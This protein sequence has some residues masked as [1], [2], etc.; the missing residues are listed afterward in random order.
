M[1]SS[2][3]I[4]E[5]ICVYICIWAVFVTIAMIHA[6]WPSKESPPPRQR[7]SST[8]RQAAEASV[9]RLQTRVDAGAS[10]ALALESVDV[11]NGKREHCQQLD[12]FR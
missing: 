12:I 2:L 4:Q 9:S 8:H 11:E 10:D 5:E 1:T 6:L 3:S 7:H